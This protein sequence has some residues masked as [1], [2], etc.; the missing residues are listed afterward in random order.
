MLDIRIIPICHCLSFSKPDVKFSKA[1]MTKFF[2]VL[3]QPIFLRC[4]TIIPFCI[5]HM[6]IRNVPCKP[7]RSW[8]GDA[9]VVDLIFCR[10][11]SQYL[12]LALTTN[13]YQYYNAGLY[14]PVLV[15][16]DRFPFRPT[17]T[18]DTTHKPCCY[19]QHKAQF[20]SATIMW[21]QTG[22]WLSQWMHNL[23]QN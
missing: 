13:N 18:L 22:S 12:Y 8:W 21:C 10:L 11:V 7:P 14:V 20:R 4:S 6:K 19:P 2:H 5:D 23:L 1:G 9:A 15:E 17:Y 16:L 3:N